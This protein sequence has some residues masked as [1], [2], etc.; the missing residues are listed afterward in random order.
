MLGFPP[1]QLWAGRSVSAGIVSLEELRRGNIH[2]D[3]YGSSVGRTRGKRQQ[4][5]V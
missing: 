1:T 4:E 5:E 3:S 2:I